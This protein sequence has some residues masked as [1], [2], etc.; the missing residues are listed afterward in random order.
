M[1]ISVV[2]VA[3]Q[4]A[5]TI[6]GTIESFLRQKHPEKEMLVID[7]ASPDETVAIALGFAAPEIRVVSEPDLGM[8]DAMNKGLR[9]YQGD[10][11]GFLNADDR[12]RDDDSLSALAAG[13]SHAD[14]AYGD[15]RIVKD[16]QSK[17]VR[18]YW[19]AD[20]FRRRA[21]RSGWVP[22]HP[23]FYALR[24]VYDEVGFFSLKYRISSDY[25]YML[26]ALLHPEFRTQYIPRCLVDFQT[27]G[28]STRGLRSVITSN[29]ECHDSRKRWIGAGI[30]D[31]ALVLK[32]YSKVLQYFS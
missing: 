19:R 13:L 20:K 10:A 8:Y 7:G 15:L 16:H 18:R 2:T 17:V 4:A 25:D 26:R 31:P 6:A 28:I 9:L 3:F 32:P 27:G 14:I 1:K 12:F 24:R 22:P 30:F 11:V 29:L 23:T 5:K 21:L